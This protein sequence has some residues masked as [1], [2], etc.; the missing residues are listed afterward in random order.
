[1]PKRKFSPAEDARIIAMVAER[2][3]NFSKIAAT[4]KAEGFPPRTS[5]SVHTRAYRLGIG[6][7]DAAAGRKPFSGEWTPEMDAILRDGVARHRGWAAIADE[8][9]WPTGGRRPENVRA[10]AV[11]LGFVVEGIDLDPV[12]VDVRTRDGVDRLLRTLQAVHK[13]PPANVRPT[14]FDGMRFD[15]RAMMPVGGC[16]GSPAAMCVD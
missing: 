6:A 9:R 14:P 3:G 12:K 8:L 15:W 5:K 11:R 16:A 1:M 2:A 4:L 7:A 13:A 10:R